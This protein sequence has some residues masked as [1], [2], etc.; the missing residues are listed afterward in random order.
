MQFLTGVP[1]DWQAG[2]TSNS[3]S[4]RSIVIRYLHS[5]Q[6]QSFSLVHSYRSLVLV[7]G[8]PTIVFRHQLLVFI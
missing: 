4:G 2:S 1:S 5:P 6:W 3:S 8:F 7:A